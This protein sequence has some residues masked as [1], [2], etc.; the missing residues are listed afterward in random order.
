MPSDHPSAIKAVEKQKL[1]LGLLKE[2]GKM[3]WY[4][5]FNADLIHTGQPWIYRLNKRYPVQ[6]Q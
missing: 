5:G 2:P 1:A 4:Y 6:I 3:F